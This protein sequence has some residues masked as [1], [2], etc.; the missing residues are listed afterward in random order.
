MTVDIL[1]VVEFVDIAEEVLAVTLDVG[2]RLTDVYTGTDC[3]D[4][5]GSMRD[6]FSSSLSLGV[7]ITLSC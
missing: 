6:H 2:K 1:E 5:C 4:F 7:V 3:K